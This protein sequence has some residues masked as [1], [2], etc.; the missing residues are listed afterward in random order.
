VAPT[1]TVHERELS[2]R[3]DSFLRDVA[4]PTPFVVIDLDVVTEQYH[5]LQCALPMAGIFYAV[6]ANPDADI[7]RLLADLGS[8]F[9]V[10]SRGE[11]D[12][13][14][15]LGVPAERI[16]YGNTI[17]RARD[18][19]Y[20]HAVGIRRYT[21]DAVEE[22]DKVLEQAPGA[23]VVV[24]LFHT[25]VGADWPLSRKFGCEPAEAVQLLVRATQLGASRTGISFHVGSQQRSPEGWDDVL[26]AT[27]QVFAEARALGARPDI[28]NLGGGFPAHYVDNIPAISRYGISISASLRR[29]FGEQRIEVMAEPGRYLVADAGV[30]RTEVVLVSNRSV[31]DGKRWVYLDCGKFG[32]LAETMDEAIRYRLRTDHEG[33]PTGAVVLAG[34]TCD[35]ADVLYE[36]ADY[37]LPLALAAGDR[38]DILSAGAYTTSYSAVGFNGFPPLASYVLGVTTAP[39]VRA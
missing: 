1:R 11:I 15:S 21:V 36:K 7:L 4:P 12:L 25:G 39:E 18:V 9:D 20:A 22:L 29:W 23:E 38:V 37:V 8:S 27:A 24:R 2:P 31:G 13:V 19:A 6:K 35:S 14:M 30:L 17:K 16:S 3:I 34:P 10:A 32:G 5:R 28:V 33:G 26:A